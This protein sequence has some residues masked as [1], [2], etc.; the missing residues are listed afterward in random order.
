VFDWQNFYS[1]VGLKIV[2]MRKNHI[3]I[4]VLSLLLSVS[5]KKE[6]EVPKKNATVEEQPVLKKES[7]WIEGEWINNSK[8]GDFTEIWQRDTD[9]TYIGKSFVI[10]RKDTVFYEKLNLTTKNDTLFYTVSVRNQN[11][12]KPVSF[13]ATKEEASQLVFE[14]PKHDFPTKIA[15][16]KITNDSMVAVVSGQGK[17]QVFPMKRKSKN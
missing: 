7:L 9:S 8:Q 4:I 10:V 5:C 3:L 2:I 17:S 6:Q 1:I 12:E 16:T 13:Y 15:Y 11:K 14:N